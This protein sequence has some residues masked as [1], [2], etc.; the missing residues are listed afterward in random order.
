[1]SPYYKIQ[2]W[3]FVSDFFVFLVTRVTQ[4]NYYVNAFTCNKKKISKWFIFV[5][6]FITLLNQKIVES[7]FYCYM[8]FS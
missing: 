5:D 1:M 7:G 8:P 2:V 6:S 3:D 4:A